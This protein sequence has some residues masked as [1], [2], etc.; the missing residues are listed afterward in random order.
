MIGTIISLILLVVILGVL[1]WAGQR[2][3][4]LIPLAEPFRTILYVLMI[5]LTVFLVLYVLIVLLSA[6]GIHVPVFS[7]IK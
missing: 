1:F 2:L 3:M 6:V 5:L 4:A 7:E